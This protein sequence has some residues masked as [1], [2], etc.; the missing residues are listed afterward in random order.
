MPPRPPA[1]AVAPR[2]TTHAL[3]AS[4]RSL[5]HPPRRSKP[6]ERSAARARPAAPRAV[7][8][9]ARAAEASASDLLRLYLDAAGC[10]VTR[11]ADEEV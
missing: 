7:A 11:I 6:P 9:P 1:G 5:S 3:L 8:A 10:S 4:N 2:A